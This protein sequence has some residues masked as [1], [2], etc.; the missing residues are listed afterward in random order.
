MRES[1]DGFHELLIRFRIQAIAAVGAS[2]GLIG[3][4]A[5][6]TADNGSMS[7]NLL[8]VGL[9]TLLLIWSVIALIDSEYYFR[10][11]M[12]AVEELTTIEADSG[13][14]LRL[15][16]RLSAKNYCSAEHSKKIM[17]AFYLLPGGAL[18]LL[19]FVSSWQNVFA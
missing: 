11:L 4:A 5:R 9:W 10:L 16:Q 17:Y 6:T 12:G 2:G 8:S 15:S 13:G 14:A 18:F 19:A 1:G 7:W 3:V